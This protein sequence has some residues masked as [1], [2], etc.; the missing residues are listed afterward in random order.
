MA[1]CFFRHGCNLA[2]ANLQWMPE[3]ALRRGN[4]KFERRFRFI[5][6]AHWADAG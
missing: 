1:I 3:E 4:E 5:R 6:A 2:A